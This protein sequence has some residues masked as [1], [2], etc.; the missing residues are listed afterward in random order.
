MAIPS[1]R[2]CDIKYIR[3]AGLLVRLF[4]GVVSEMDDFE[5]RWLKTTLAGTALFFGLILGDFA[6]G[7]FWALFAVVFKTRTYNFAAWW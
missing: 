1:G 4:L 2:L 7:G 6:V 5:V 3:N